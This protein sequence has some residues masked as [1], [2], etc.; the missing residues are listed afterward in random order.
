MKF[1]VLDPF[2]RLR[3]TYRGKVCLMKNPLD[4][5]DPK[6]AF[7]ENP[8]VDCA[9]DLEYL[10]MSPVYGGERVDDE[11]RPLREKPE[12]AFARAHYEQHVTGAGTIRVAEREYAVAGRVLRFLP[13]RSRRKTPDGG[14]LHTRIT[15]G[16]TEYRC[17]GKVGYGMSEY[18]DQIVD[19]RP[20]GV[21]RP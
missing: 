18:L 5:A 3:L 13:L 19:G 6:R 9:V 16:M 20:V 14:L 17:D 15:E 12:E 11:G 21:D 7:T 4:M 10:G 8:L 2:K 1:E